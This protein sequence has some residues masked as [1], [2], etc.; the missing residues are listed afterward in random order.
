MH[1]LLWFVTVLE[2]RIWIKGINNLI[3]YEQ[4]SQ[5]I[6]N[7]DTEKAFASPGKSFITDLCSHHLNWQVQ[8]TKILKTQAQAY[9][10][11]SKYILG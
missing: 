2:Q 9:L 5:Y 7:S 3:Y 6:K 1:L 8:Y 10:T 11:F 4:E